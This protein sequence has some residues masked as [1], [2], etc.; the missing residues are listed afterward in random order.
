LAS[1]GEE[2]PKNP[3]TRQGPSACASP[4]AGAGSASARSAGQRR[5]LMRGLKARPGE[6]HKQRTQRVHDAAGA[7]VVLPDRG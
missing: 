6:F 4:G 1:G 7:P 5:R 2:L 3:L